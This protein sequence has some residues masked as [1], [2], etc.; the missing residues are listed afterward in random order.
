MGGWTDSN[1]G[2]ELFTGKLT[3]NRNLQV[4]VT[5][6]CGKVR[7]YHDSFRSTNLGTSL[8]RM[9]VVC[10][11]NSCRTNLSCLKV[12]SVMMANWV[13]RE[14]VTVL[15]GANSN[16]SEKLSLLMISKSAKPRCFTLLHKYITVG[17]SDLLCDST[18]I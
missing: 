14:R 13:H 6:V 1:R 9:S 11:L 5:I 16:G 2:T 17:S 7:F 10:F 8:M 15:V 12:K 4:T 18:R 3:A